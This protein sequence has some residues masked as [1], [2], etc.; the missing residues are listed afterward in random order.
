M[1][2]HGV[3]SRGNAVL[4]TAACVSLLAIGAVVVAVVLRVQDQNR[5]EQLARETHESL[6]ALKTDVKHRASNTQ[7]FLDEIRRG[8][9]PQIPGISIAD[10]ER[11]LA[12]QRATLLALVTLK[13][14][15][16]ANA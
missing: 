12:S 2:E 14:T 15:E 8:D 11:S 10:L 3:L 7:R 4:L 16:G 9:R 5:F 1:N 13:C 6:C